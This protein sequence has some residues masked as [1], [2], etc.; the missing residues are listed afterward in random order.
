MVASIQRVADTAKSCRIPNPA[1]K[2]QG[3]S[4]RGHP[5]H[6]K[7]DRRVKPHQRTITSS[8]K[9]RCIG[10]R[11]TTIGKIIEASGRSGEQTNLLAFERSH[12]SGGEP[13]HGW[14][15][16]G[17]GRSAQAGGKIRAQST[18]EIS[19]DPGIRRSGARQWRNGRPPAL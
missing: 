19:N 15:S 12:R 14:A 17:G 8:E 16:L 1:R 4:T 3:R 11:A 6:G 13:G 18:K 5:P 7:G 10:Q 9:Y 2:K